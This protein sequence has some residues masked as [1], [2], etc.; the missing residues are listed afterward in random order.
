MATNMYARVYRPRNQSALMGR[1]GRGRMARFVLSPE[2][3]RSLAILVVAALVV[4]LVVTQFF[5]GRMMALRADAEQLRTANVSLVGE[6]SRLQ[7]LRAQLASKS[8]VLALA[9]VKLNLHEPDRTQVH[10]M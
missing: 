4:G 8:H 3:R 7:T 10:R 1:G 6:H 9:G 5:Y 2:V